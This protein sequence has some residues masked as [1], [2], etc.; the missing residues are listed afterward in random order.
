MHVNKNNAPM[1]A[2]LLAALTLV[3]AG[4]GTPKPKPVMWNVSITKITPASI[5]ID[6]VG[7]A[8]MQKPYLTNVK[9]DDYWKPGN[10]IRAG[11]KKVTARLPTGQPWILKADDPIWQQ[12]KSYGTT[13]L[14]IMATLPCK[15]CGDGPFD[16][17]RLFV[18]LDKH[19][20]NAKHKTLEFE[21]QD[22][23]IRPLTPQAP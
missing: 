9:V 1:L 6:L 10:S 17:R 13:E 7:V 16:R 5:E 8:P 23:M 12:W 4:C 20:W 3:G 22:E 21:V 18:P 19:Y 11:L 15:D 2:V 14:M